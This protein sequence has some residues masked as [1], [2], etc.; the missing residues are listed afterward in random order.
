MAN[1]TR[2]SSAAS[3]RAF[4]QADTKGRVSLGKSFAKALLI[5]EVSDD[6][7]TVVLRRA[8][9]I[10]TQQAWLFKNP[11]AANLVKQGL[12]DIKA[13]RVTKGP[14]LDADQEL[15]DQLED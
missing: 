7:A 15:V 11:R 9:A 12:A 13:G 2:A 6:G 5:V 8:E 10:P 4:G 1:S 3:T 14:D